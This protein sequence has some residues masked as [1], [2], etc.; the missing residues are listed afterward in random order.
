MPMLPRGATGPRCASRSEIFP[1]AFRISSMLSF[2][3]ATPAES[4]PRYSRRRRAG[5]RTEMASRVPQ[6][7]TMPHMAPS[8]RLGA[9]FL[10]HLVLHRGGVSVGPVVLA[11]TGKDAAIAVQDDAADLA[12]LDLV[13]R[14]LDELARRPACAD[15]EQE[16]VDA[17][18]DDAR[19]GDREERRA[20][21]DDPVEVL[22]RRAHDLGEARRA[23]DPVR[24]LGPLARRN[25]EETPG[26]PLDEDVAQRQPWVGHELDQASKIPGEADPAR[27]AR[28]AQVRVDDQDPE[29]RVLGERRGEVQGRRSLAVSDARPGHGQDAEIA[30]ALLVIEHVAEV[31]VLLGFER[32]R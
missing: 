3:V 32:H 23:Q 28:P 10:F 12:G 6:Y 30:L 25:D 26:G 24:V 31:P 18:S 22:P 9:G 19:V 13:Q 2:T 8:G 1:A 20:I 21:Q 29:S 14:L 11:V 27:H 16:P 5:M 7:P 4:Y 17:V 15:D